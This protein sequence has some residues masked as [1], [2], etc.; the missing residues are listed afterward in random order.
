MKA[1]VFQPLNSIY[2]HIFHTF[3]NRNSAFKPL[4]SNT[5]LRPYI[6]NNLKSHVCWH[7]YG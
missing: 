7:V 2:S 1:L 3:T 4:V 5:N 6:E